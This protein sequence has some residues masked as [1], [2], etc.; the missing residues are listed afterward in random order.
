MAATPSE[1]RLLDLLILWEESRRQGRDPAAE[2]LCADC[3]DLVDELRLR[4]GAVL[5]VVPVLE[6]NASAQRSTSEDGG[7]GADATDF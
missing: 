3:P 7:D 6:S 5:A 1:E 2:E 4:M